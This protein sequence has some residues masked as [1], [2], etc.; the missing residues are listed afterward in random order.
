MAKI[1][2]DTDDDLKVELNVYLARNSLTLK[3]F[4][5]EFIKEEVKVDKDRQ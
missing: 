5:T 1:M 3:E 2:C 4:I